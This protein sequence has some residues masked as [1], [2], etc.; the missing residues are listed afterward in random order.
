MS[1][2]DRDIAVRGRT[3]AR[4]LRLHA[5]VTC[6]PPAELA[7]SLA[8]ELGDLDADRVER[9]LCALGAAVLAELESDPEAQL[10]AL[11][12]AVTNSALAARQGGGPDELMIDRALERGHGPPVL[13]AI[14]LAE[15]GRR[16]GTRPT[17]A[18]APSER[19]RSAPRSPK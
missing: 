10:R 3:L 14:L 12:E 5:S 17:P 19:P 2:S 16:A 9:A 1:T 15:I 6:P 8:W 4:P 18:P 7:T 13:I 11:G